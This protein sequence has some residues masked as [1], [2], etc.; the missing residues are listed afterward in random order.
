[1]FE[2]AERENYRRHGPKG[3][4]AFAAHSNS[5]IYSSSRCRA[6]VAMCAILNMFRDR[7]R[8]HYSYLY[9]TVVLLYS[10]TVF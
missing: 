10:I 7:V 6:G 2:E 1:M 4:A 8:N 9:C 5:C 3:R